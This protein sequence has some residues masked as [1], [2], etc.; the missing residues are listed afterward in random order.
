V[1]RGTAGVA[2]PIARLIEAFNK[3]PGVG[4]KSAQRLAFHLLRAPSQET[5]ELADALLSM[6]EAIVFCGT[7]QNVTAS[8][9]CSICAS[10]SRDGSLLCVVEEPLDVVAIERTQGF[11]GRYYVL[12]G[13]ISPM[14]GIGPDQLRMAG[15]LQRI[16][17]GEIQEMIVATNP[18]LEGE[19]T[20][21]YLKRLIGPLGVRVTRLA[22]G[23]P[24]GGDLEYADEVTL[25]RAFEGRHEMA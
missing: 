21:L 9:P 1:D 8:D 14:D 17:G 2:P 13:A 18:T 15:L 11:R 24:I 22:R 25:T 12:H 20:A 23:L 19:A 6:K 7:C 5:R 3:L 10:V 4:P 16:G